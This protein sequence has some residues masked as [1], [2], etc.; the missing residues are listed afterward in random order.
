MKRRMSQHRGGSPTTVGRLIQAPAWGI[1]GRPGGSEVHSAMNQSDQP[2]KIAFV[3]DYLPRQCGIATF[4]HDLRKAVAAQDPGAE[5]GVLAVNDQPEGYEY[6]P[7]VRFEIGEQRL[8]DYQE[9]VNFLRFNGFDVICLQHEFGIFGGRAGSHVLA[10]LREVDLPVVTTL[11][12]ILEEP[13]PD[14]RRVMDEI[15]RQSE[16]LVVMTERGRRI[17]QETYGAPAARIDLIAHGIP[18]TPFVEPSALKDQ[19]GLE[20]RQVLL[21]FGLLSPGKGIEYVIRSLPEIT[22]QHPDLI[23]VVLGATHP[24]LVRAEGESYRLSL[25]RLAERLGMTQ[26]VAFY[27][28]FVELEELEQFIGAADIYITPYLTRAQATSGTLCYAFGCGKPVISTPYWHAEE[29]LAEDR[30]VLVPFHDS[31]SIAAAVCGLLAD[32]ARL[33]A[34]RARAYRAGRGMIWSEAARHYLASFRRA[35]RDHRHLHG[36]RLAVRTLA[37]QLFEL[38]ELTLDHIERLTN[39]I[40]IFQHAAYAM[41]SYADGYCTDDNARALLLMILL[42]GSDHDTL[43]RRQLATRYSAFLQHAFDRESRRFRNFMSFDRRWLEETGSD[44]CCGRCLWVL[45]ICLARSRHRSFQKWAAELFLHAL[46]ALEAMS[47]PRAWAFGLIGVQAYLQH[48]SGDRNVSA[49]SDRLTERLIHLYDEQSTPDWPWFEP[50]LSYVNAKLP[51]ALICSGRNGGVHRQRALELG[52]ETLRW[53]VAEQ[54]QGGHFVPI[55][56][57]GFYRRGGPRARFD[58]QPIEAQATVSACIEAF[59]ATGDGYWREEAQRAFEW[60]L[61]RNDLDQPLYNPSSGGCYDGLHFDRVNLNQGAELT[62]AFLLALAEMTSLQIAPVPSA[63]VTARRQGV[64][65]L[66]PSFAEI[67][68]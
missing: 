29:L 4:T 36:P 14:Q 30:G 35:R 33:D 47:S 22:R 32:E 68:K 28:R 23:Y 8:R 59:E 15:V 37:E 1:H 45:G 58:Q 64:P 2:T 42:E 26:H 6:A 18:D 67:H 46:P 44:D 24:H 19:F 41:P 10:I 50:V 43:A 61:G 63:E 54:T 57:N 53:L 60:F 27:N 16:R 48:L 5:C 9:A 34:M 38:P 39:S 55:G 20:D 65:G 52:V 17:L 25:E 21:T 62:L 7:E 12:T 56:S 13:T 3:S 40:G 66:S 31:A 11:H 51:H 49:I